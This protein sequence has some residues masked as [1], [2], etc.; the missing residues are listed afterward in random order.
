[1]MQTVAKKKDTSRPLNMIK[2][3]SGSSDTLSSGNEKDV[4]NSKK[5]QKQQVF[6]MPVLELRKSINTALVS[7]VQS[8][9]SLDESSLKELCSPDIKE[10]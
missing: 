5:E 1:M 6:K 3:A 9:P 2:I 10:N 7:R 8:H 4:I